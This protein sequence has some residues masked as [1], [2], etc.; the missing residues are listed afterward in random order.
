MIFEE[1][2]YYQYYWPDSPECKSVYL[3]QNRLGKSIGM[4]YHDKFIRADGPTL[5]LGYGIG[6]WE[7]FTEEMR[8]IL[9]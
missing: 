6:V 2:K 9:L 5:N 4:I 7:E 1:G 3:C 8:A